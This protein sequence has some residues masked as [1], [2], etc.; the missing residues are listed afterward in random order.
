MALVNRVIAELVEKVSAQQVDQET[1][2]DLGAI[3]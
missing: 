1:G 3:G 2:H